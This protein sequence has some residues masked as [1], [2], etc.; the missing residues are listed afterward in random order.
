MRGKCPALLRM[1]RKIP[2]ACRRHG[3]E[4]CSKCRDD[5]ES[6]RGRNASEEAKAKCR[7]RK[8]TEGALQNAWCVTPLKKRYAHH[9]GEGRVNPPKMR[10]FQNL[11]YRKGGMRHG[12]PPNGESPTV[13]GSKI[14]AAHGVDPVDRG[15]FMGNAPVS[16]RRMPSC[17]ADLAGE[18]KVGLSREIR[19]FLEGLGPAT[20]GNCR[21]RWCSAQPD[22]PGWAETGKNPP[23]DLWGIAYARGSEGKGPSHLLG[24]QGR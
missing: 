8:S 19:D 14:R 1:R 17:Y 22:L 6:P 3:A 24:A 2:P 11:K 21:T 9:G 12:R 15:V 10:N 7:G 23:E 13:S 5:A 16:R 18:R 20:C 4:K